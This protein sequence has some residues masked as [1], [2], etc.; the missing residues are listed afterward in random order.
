MIRCDN[1]I[2]L[3]I[4]KTESNNQIIQR[5]K[6]YTKYEGE[7]EIVGFDPQ[8]NFYFDFNGVEI[9]K[10]RILYTT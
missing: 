3:L 10:M 9:C 8:E 5:I 2:E 1:I 6:K 4:T 7:I